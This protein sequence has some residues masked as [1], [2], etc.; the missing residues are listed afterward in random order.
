[1]AGGLNVV[2]GIAAI[3]NANFFVNDERFVVSDLS[4]WGWV[5]LVFGVVLVASAIGI[6]A[7]NRLAVLV[8]IGALLFNG[9]VQLFFLPANPWWAVTVFALDMLAMYGLVVHGEKPG[10]RG[11]IPS[12]RREWQ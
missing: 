2:S 7:A 12:D 9:M 6:F 11:T 8:G 4:T 5:H 1:M 10:A 3:D